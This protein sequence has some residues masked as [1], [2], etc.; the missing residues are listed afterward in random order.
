MVGPHLDPGSR[1]AGDLPGDDRNLRQISQ[2]D[3]CERHAG[4]QTPLGVDAEVQDAT[5]RARKDVDSEGVGVGNQGLDEGQRSGIEFR[6]SRVHSCQSSVWFQSSRLAWG[7]RGPQRSG[8][9]YNP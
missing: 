1:R 8:R 4:F 5:R 2:A 7:P 9:H 6:S 3:S